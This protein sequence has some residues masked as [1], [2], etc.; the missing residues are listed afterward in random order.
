MMIDPGAFTPFYDDALC[1]ALAAEGCEV[2][3]VTA[4]FVYHPWPAAVGYARREA[5]A[6]GA[7]AHGRALR[8]LRRL[9]RAAAYP[10]AWRRLVRE[11]ERRPPE[12]VHLQ[13]SLLP[14]IERRALRRLRAAGVA[15]VET[16]HNARPHG[17]EWSFRPAGSAPGREADAWVA[18]SAATAATLTAEYPDRAERV[19]LIPPGIDA[20]AG[21]RP[22]GSGQPDGC[23][24]PDA[25]GR[26]ARARAR[27][28]LDPTAPVALFLGLIRP[29][30]GLD[31]LLEAFT[32]VLRGLPEARLVVAGLPRPSFRPYARQMAR[33]GLGERVRTDL[34]YLPQDVMDD[35]LAAADLVVL[36]YRGASQSAVLGA[37]LA[38]D[39]P[40]VASATGGLPEMLAEV[41]AEMLVPAGDVVALE[42]A[43]SRLLGDRAVAA[44][45]GRRAGRAARQRFSWARS[46]TATV[47]LYR[48]L[49]QAIGRQAPGRR[50]S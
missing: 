41:A 13:W 29:Y 49:A 8:V 19:R 17:G 34:R 3:L 5:F 11:L 43:M 50:T 30:K 26:A 9:R 36:P 25:D 10:L 24:E 18:L 38:R 44:E 7:G 42:R 35:Y 47:E 33:L 23:G 12:I 2:E 46:A 31:L 16:V 1:R 4:P 32:G 20:P 37:A 14:A 6:G 27:L 40:V 48:E 28:G 21:F 45:L 22:G 39:R 15:W